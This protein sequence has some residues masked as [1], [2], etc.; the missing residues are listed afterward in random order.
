M[1][2]GL[3]VREKE[4]ATTGIIR[5]RFD[6]MKKLQAEGLSI[7]GIAKQLGMHR[8]TGRAYRPLQ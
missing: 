2:F 7:K 8:D 5:Q 6:E 1:M 4:V 3:S